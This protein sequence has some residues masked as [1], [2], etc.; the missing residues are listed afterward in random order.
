MNRYTYDIQKKKDHK[1][2]RDNYQIIQIADIHLD[3]LYSI[4]SEVECGETICCRSTDS[5]DNKVSAGHWGSYPCDIPF[6][7]VYNTFTGIVKNAP[8]ADLWYSTGDV[9]P[10]DSWQSSKDSNINN[11]KIISRFLEKFAKTTVI[12][13]IGNHESVPVNRFV[14]FGNF[15]KIVKLNISAICRLEC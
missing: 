12:S 6:E 1:D 15:S 9:V 5:I 14:N 3:T 10:H 4:G 11:F 8:N 13:A 7:T 2:D